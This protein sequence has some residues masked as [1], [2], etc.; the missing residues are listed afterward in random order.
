MTYS[1]KYNPCLWPTPLVDED[2]A[3]VLTVEGEPIS[4]GRARFGKGRAYTPKETRIHEDRLKVLLLSVRRCGTDP[5]SRFGLRC[6]FFRSDRRRI[7]CDNLIKAV[8]DAATG[9]IWKDDSQVL[10]V[11]GRLFVQSDVPRTMVA[12]YRVPDT[13]TLLSCPTCAKS[14][15]V[16]G[17]GHSRKAVF[18]SVECWNRSTRVDVICKQCGIS[19]ELRVSSARRR[20]GFCSRSCS[21]LFHG[22]VKTA[23]R[24]PATW[25]CEMC[26][27]HVSRREYKRCRGCSMKLRM[28]GGSNYWLNRVPKKPFVPLGDPNPRAEV[29]VRLI[30]AKKAKAGT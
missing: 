19:F 11:M 10:E 30:E 17:Q 24:G 29:E 16:P 6:V 8:S 5:T 20:A 21:M 27:G 23:A 25:L 1:D 12:I 22:A 2:I 18:C 15:R 26:G 14:F 4:K 28:A 3:A 7:D 13:D 9:V